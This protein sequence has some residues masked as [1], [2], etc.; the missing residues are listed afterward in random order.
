MIPDFVKMQ[1]RAILNAAIADRK[2]GGDPHAEIMIPLVGH[3]NELADTKANPRGRGE[4]GPG[5]RRRRRST[6]SSG[7]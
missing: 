3:V 5:G 1:T 7:R 6:T 4:G 2:A